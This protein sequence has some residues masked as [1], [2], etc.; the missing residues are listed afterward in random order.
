MGKSAKQGPGH[1][2]G[3]PAGLVGQNEAVGP[4]GA[5]PPGPVGAVPVQGVG[6]HETRGKQEQTQSSQYDFHLLR[7][8]LGNQ[9]NDIKL[10]PVFVGYEV[11]RLA[12]DGAQ[13]RLRSDVSPEC[14]SLF[15]RNNP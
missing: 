9:A 8:F 13:P 2:G 1:P 11:I 6:T 7:P 15:R 12:R 5:G 4:A 14:V 10:P 3:L